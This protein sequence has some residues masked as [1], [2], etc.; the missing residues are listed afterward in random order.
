M[1]SFIFIDGSRH[2]TNRTF[3]YTA[4]GVCEGCGLKKKDEGSIKF[5]PKIGR[6]TCNDCASPRGY[7]ATVNML[8]EPDPLRIMAS[9]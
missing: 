8:V 5:R 9:L 2:K 1:R 7:A 6:V 3:Y 4:P